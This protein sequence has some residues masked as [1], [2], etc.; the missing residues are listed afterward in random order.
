MGLCLDNLMVE[1]PMVQFIS[2]VSSNHSR[3]LKRCFAFIDASARI[4]C[5]AVKFQ[6]FKI[7]Q[8]FAPEI[9]ARSEKHRKRRDWELPVSFLPELAA[10]SH[11]RG[12]E[13]SCTPFYLQAVD[14]L[15][16]HVDFFKIASYELMWTDLLVA[17]AQT[18]RPLVL[19]TGMATLAEIDVAVEAVTTA[20]CRQLTLL[21]CVSGYPAPP[22]ECNLAAIETLRVRYGCPVGWSDHSVAPGVIQRAVHRWNASTVEFHLDLEGSGAEFASGHCWLP[23]K[24]APVISDIRTALSA[25]GDG[26]KVPTAS[27]LPDRAWRADPSDGLR[28]LLKTR[29]EWNE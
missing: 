21:H 28:P 10:R 4:G 14:E 6:L 29:M 9:L 17:C 12:I 16:P 15:V 24:I 26:S 3:D 19:S 27:E 25:D 8:L 7:D 5:N 18:G 11:D 1:K 22:G 23:D 13:F 20:G 2:E